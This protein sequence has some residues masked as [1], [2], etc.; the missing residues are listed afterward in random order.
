MNFTAIDWAILIAYL[1]VTVF[2][3]IW[4]KK[5]VQNLSGYVVAGRKIKVSL[6]IATFTATELGTVTFVYFGELGY[7]TGFACFI[8][9]ILALFAYTFVG[10]T[11]F[12]IEKLREYGMMTIPEF[13]ELRYN[14]KVRILGGL[15]LFIGGVLNMGIFLKF[16]GI[17]LSEVMGFG[18]QALGFIMTLMLVIV[19][20]YTILGGMFSVVIT[21]FMQYVVLSF[22]MLITT[23][24]V[25]LE[26]DLS[27]I[28]DAVTSGYG[29]GGV[30]PIINPRFGWSFIIWILV[31]NIAAAALWQPGTSKALSSKSPEVAKKVFWFTGLTFAG[32]AMIP[33]F[34]GVAAFAYFGPGENT[35]AAMPM[36][37][38][39]LLPVGLL[40]LLVAG[41]LA[42]SMS[43]YSSYVLAW[44]SV[45]TLDVISTLSP[46]GFS[47]ERKIWIARFV[48]GLIGLFLLVFGLWYQIP[49]TAFQYIFITGTMY[50]AGALGTVSAGLYWK[51]ANAVGAHSALIL[52]AV[53]PAGFLVLEKFSEH[54]PGWLAFITDV[55]FAGFLSFILAALG[56]ILGSLLTQK[57]SPAK[58]IN[59]A[60]IS[61]E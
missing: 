16:D 61:Y 27:T 43:T 13:Y 22:A 46:N 24:I 32:R 57:K 23:I 42:A 39:E 8:I 29:E 2:I 52:G 11:G 19:M 28:S 20:S 9:G 59:E 49:E 18:P 56:M 33:M 15:I 25:I 35:A 3:G 60:E 55:N 12:I 50:T 38:G 37:L 51:K 4:V 47:E 41:L 31:T 1:S 36:L 40:G 58:V 10:K 53:V 5:Y 26:V 21:D 48:A 7:V 17:F 34:W 44:S 54:L 45:L 30:N 6:G 14:K